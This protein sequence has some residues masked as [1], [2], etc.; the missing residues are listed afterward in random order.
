MIA[1]LYIYIY[2]VR[3]NTNVVLELAAIDGNR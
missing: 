1:Y 2:S 3:E